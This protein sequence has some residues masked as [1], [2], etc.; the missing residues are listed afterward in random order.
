MHSFHHRVSAIL[1]PHS[2]RMRE[3]RTYGSV[4][5]VRGNSHPYRDLGRTKRATRLSAHGQAQSGTPT[6][7]PD[8]DRTR[9]PFVRRDRARDRNPGYGSGPVATAREGSALHAD[10]DPTYSAAS[11]LAAWSAAIS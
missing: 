11:I 6:G 8:C 7:S 3:S 2:D 9:P 4:R 5:G 10:H 1:G